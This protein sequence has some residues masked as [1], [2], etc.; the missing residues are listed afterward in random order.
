MQVPEST[1]HPQPPVRSRRGTPGT[2]ALPGQMNVSLL[3][4]QLPRL[5]VCN[6]EWAVLAHSSGW[7]VKRCMPAGTCTLLQMQIT[8]NLVSLGYEMSIFGGYSFACLVRLSCVCC[9]GR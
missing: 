1:H 3:Q 2:V 6:P 4:K 8:A 5:P 9:L 7:A